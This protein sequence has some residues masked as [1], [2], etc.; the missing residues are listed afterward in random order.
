M[1]P[2]ATTL[3]KVLLNRYHKG[4]LESAISF[5]PEDAALAVR[6]NPTGSQN[7]KPALA[8][9]EDQIKRIHW[10]WLKPF[11]SQQS[12]KMLPLFISSLPKEQAQKLSTA[13]K[14]SPIENISPPLKHFL[15]QQVSAAVVD[16]NVL[17]PPYLPESPLNDLVKLSKSELLT[18]IDYFGLYDLAE[19]IRQIVDKRYIKQIYSCFSIRKQEFL[20]QALHQRERLIPTHINLE[21][22]KGDCLEL[23]QTVHLRGLLRLG[24]A[25]S[26]QH[27]DLIWLIGH[28][29]DTG[30][31]AV[32]SECSKKEKAPGIAPALTHQLMNLMN[33]LKPKPAS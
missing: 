2:K 19:T 26:D 8:S 21:K 30:R 31:A 17:L 13:F 28:T 22:W 20:R 14:I 11:L 6:Q 4:S 27:P 32:L 5:L 1:S 3:L 10:S 23:K 12:K 24:M 33:F 18:L 15:L 16:P 25:L 29:L 9:V 7:L